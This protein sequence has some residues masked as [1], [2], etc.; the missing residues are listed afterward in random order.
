LTLNLG[1]RWDGV[2][3]TYEA[4]DRMGNFYSNLYDPAKAALLNP[5][6][7]INSASPGLG[8]SP[9]PLIAIGGVP[10]PLYLNGIGIPGKN[11]IPKG[12]V[13]NHWAAFGP[14]IGFAYDVTGSGK[15]VVRGGG[16]LMYE[17]IQGNDMYNAG[18]N[19]PFS[20]Q[21]NESNVEM[22]NPNIALASGAAV[23]RPIL[24]AGITG[25][26]VN[27]YKLP[28]SYQWSAGVQHSLSSKTVLSVTY[29]GNQGRHQ[30]DYR[31]TNLPTN[32]P[33]VLTALATGSNYNI[34]PGLT[35]PG[36]NSIKQAENEANTHYKV[37]D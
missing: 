35:Y 21:V 10:V 36:F 17:R 15:T 19:I 3:H 30:N 9:N 27:G 32:S 26:D 16:G 37:A 28:V 22:G 8:F 25:L 6:G 7:T 33:A 5:D 4:N 2:P 14:R 24:P 34:A 23:T 18:P 1:L 13:D 12:L 29:V 11:G 31:N 20:L